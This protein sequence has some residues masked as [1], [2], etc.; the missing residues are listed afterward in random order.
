[1]KRRTD[2]PM[3]RLIQLIAVLG[4]LLPGLAWAASWNGL[5]P[6][7]RA[8]LQSHRGQWDR[9]PPEQQERLRQG[10]QR[11]LHLS[12]AERSAVEEQERRYRALPPER[13]RSLRDEYRKRQR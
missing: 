1:M 8:V 9:Y 11:Y 7:E 13:Q 12:P 4:V 10:A 3:R 6:E 5:S 2:E